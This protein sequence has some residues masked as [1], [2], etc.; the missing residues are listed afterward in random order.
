MIVA[1]GDFQLIC[2]HS[3]VMLISIEKILKF[4]NREM[5]SEYLDLTLKKNRE[6]ERCSASQNR[7]TIYGGDL[8]GI[9]LF[10]NWEF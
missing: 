8:T 10:L 4:K 1:S 5:T 6:Q 7:E 3:E 9:G 2:T